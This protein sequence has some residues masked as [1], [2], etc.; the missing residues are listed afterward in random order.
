MGGRS[1]AAAV[2]LPT[3]PTMRERSVRSS[4]A[5]RLRVLMVVESAAGGTGRHVLDLAQGMIDRGHEVHLVYST[6]RLDRIFQARLNAM[7]RVRRVPLA[8]RTN[9]HPSDFFVVRAV[10]RYLRSHGPFDVVH[11]HS[12][13]AGAIARMAALGTGAS[14]FYTLHG[15]IM[16]DPGLAAWKRALYLGIE[17]ALSLRT[18]RIIAVSPEEGRAALRVR[19]GRSRV[20]VVPNGVDEEGA[21]APRAQAREDLRLRERDVVVGFIGRLVDQK[22]PDVLLRAFARASSA[23]TNLRLAVVGDGPLMQRMGEL[24]AE[25]DI[26]HRVLWLGERDARQVIA[27]F[28]VFAISSRKEGLPYVVLEAMAAGLPIVATSSAGV[29]LLVEPGVNGTVVPLD[30]VVG[31]GA[32]LAR[33][34]ADLALRAAQGASSRRLVANFTI[35]GM[36]EKTLGV[37]RDAL[38]PEPAIAERT[39][40]PLDDDTVELAGELT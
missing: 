4:I 31:F 12:S 27:A 3:T 36:V 13:K 10:R 17:L 25:L 8:M 28:D 16:M 9:I 14:A 26:A 22:A 23:D 2:A 15:L 6:G 39:G 7:P 11:G 37:Y 29:E 32:A 38:P 19:L 1:A 21:V 34:G 24:A 20:V 5:R 18:S 40:G 33:L 35:D 30:D